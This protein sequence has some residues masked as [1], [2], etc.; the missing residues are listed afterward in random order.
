M[1]KSVDRSYSELHDQETSTYS[2]L[3]GKWWGS[4]EESEFVVAADLRAAIE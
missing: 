3:L 1:G 4:C 2:I